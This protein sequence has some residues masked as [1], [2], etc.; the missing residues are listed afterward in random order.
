[1]PPYRD[2]T[3][4]L[5]LLALI[6][7]CEEESTATARGGWGGA[8]QVVTQQV[9]LQPMI[10]EIQALGTARANESIDIQLCQ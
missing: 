9:E 5:T 4:T 3:I 2:L 10:D 7:G 8:A 1:M 6:A